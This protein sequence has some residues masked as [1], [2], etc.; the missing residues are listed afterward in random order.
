[1]CRVPISWVGQQSTARVV[2][3]WGAVSVDG[4][5]EW[6]VKYGQVVNWRQLHTGKPI[7]SG[8][9]H[10]DDEPATTTMTMDDNITAATAI[11]ITQQNDMQ[12]QFDEDILM[13]QPPGECFWSSTSDGFVAILVT[14]GG[15]W[16]I[17][18]WLP[19]GFDL[20]LLTTVLNASLLSYGYG[21]DRQTDGRTG[22][23]ITTSLN[24]PTVGRSHNNSNNKAM[25]QWCTA[26]STLGMKDSSSLGEVMPTISGCL[27]NSAY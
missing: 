4:D 18:S 27:T 5:A 20:L 10:D 24:A 7:N 22:G 12:W 6:C 16:P 11:G 3:T 1:M 21:T 25:L 26:D 15:C 19:S 13:V 9:N 2:R 14:S 8:N 17:Q 23:W